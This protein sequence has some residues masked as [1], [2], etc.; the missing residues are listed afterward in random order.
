MKTTLA[1]IAL[2]SLAFA[3]AAQQVDTS[4]APAPKDAGIRHVQD[5]TSQTRLTVDAN[6]E[7]VPRDTECRMQRMQ[8]E[9]NSMNRRFD[10]MQEMMRRMM[11]SMSGHMMQKQGAGTHDHAQAEGS[12]Q[13]DEDANAAPPAPAP[14]EPSLPQAEHDAHH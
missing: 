2:S 9:L 6:R 5:P 10:A 4:R 11:D 3:C 8:G 13:R 12:A 14:R 7:C 1:L